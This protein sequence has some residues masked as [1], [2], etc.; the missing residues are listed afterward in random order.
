MNIIPIM[1]SKSESKITGYVIGIDLGTT[2]SC[3][4]VHRNGNTE[5]I[6]NDQGL[7]TTP[8]YVAFTDSERLIG[9][10]AKNQAAANPTNTVYDAKRLIGRKF[11]EQAVQDDLKHFSFKVVP[12]KNDKPHIDVDYLGK[13]EQFSPEQIS[14]MVLKYMKDTAEAYLGETVEHAVVTVPAY[15]NDAQRQATKDAGTIAGLNVM[16]IINEPTSAAIAYG[17]DKTGEKTV[18]IYDFGGGTLDTTL[19]TI[20][21][22]MFE[23]IS[24]AGDT[25]LGGEDIDNRLVSYVIDEFIKKNKK[26]TVADIN[27]NKRAMRRVKTA[28]EAAKRT[29]SSSTTSVVSI[30]SLHDGI[31]LNVTISR[32]KFETLCDAKTLL[33]NGFAGK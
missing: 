29:L 7:R 24:T 9:D 25:R 16:R 5:I 23:V 6:A 8:S 2:Y 27:A 22:G 30:D 15:F 13:R 10:S 32:A 31:D 18:V 12:D 17:M 26:L 33:W 28:C 20:D 19:L 11:S 14:S 21:D 1:T 4:A 3:V